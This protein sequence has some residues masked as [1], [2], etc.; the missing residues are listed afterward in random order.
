VH[1][2]AS[3]VRANSRRR[4]SARSSRGTGGPRHAHPGHWADVTSNLANA[5]SFEVDVGDDYGQLMLK[6]SMEYA[7]YLE[8]KNGYFVLS[9]V[10]E[11]GGP[12]ER[13][14]LHVLAE[15][16]PD[17]QVDVYVSDSVGNDEPDQP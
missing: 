13:A 8:A 5:Y 7:A 9:G 6:N 3:G 4:L 1:F 16:A 12:V 11:P 2:T 14:I 10:L 17:W 15:I